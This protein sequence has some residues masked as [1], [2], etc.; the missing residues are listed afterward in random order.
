MNIEQEDKILNLHLPWR[1]TM[2]KTWPELKRK[3]TDQ[4]LHGLGICAYHMALVS[5]RLILEFLGLNV[6]RGTVR[7]KNIVRKNGEKGDSIW[8]EDLGLQQ[9]PLNDLDKNDKEVLG[10]VIRGAHKVGAHFTA[11]LYPCSD[12]D[13][14]RA[15]DIVLKLVQHH[16]FKLKSRP[17]KLFESAPD[18]ILQKLPDVR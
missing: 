11:E 12:D 18:V 13:V 16:V 1:L 4:N 6:E 7:L 8:I 2:V 9:V 5:M 15:S 14:I 3:R 17:M 10:R